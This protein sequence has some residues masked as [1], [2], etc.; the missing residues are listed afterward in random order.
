MEVSSQSNTRSNRK[1]SYS[2]YLTVLFRILPRKTA[3]FPQKT[4]YKE[5]GAADSQRHRILNA[6]IKENLNV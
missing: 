2:S 3:L 4:K 1:L 6:K 5:S